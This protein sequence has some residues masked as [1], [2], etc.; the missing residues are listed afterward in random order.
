MIIESH[1]TEFVHGKDEVRSSILLEG[2]RFQAI[3]ICE[4]PLKKF[5]LR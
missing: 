1:A 5:L 2:S 4:L 3:Q